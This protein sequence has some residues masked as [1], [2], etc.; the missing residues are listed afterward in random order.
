MPEAASLFSAL[1]E[2]DHREGLAGAR[3]ERL[4]SAGRPIPGV[5]VRVVDEQGRDAP[6]GEVGEVWVRGPNVMQGYWNLPEETA[7]VLDAG[8]WYHSRDMGRLDASG[9]LTLVDR[10]GDMIV[11]GGENVY[12]TEVEDAI[13]RHEGVLEACVVGVPDPEWVEA[14]C[15]VVVR[16]PGAELDEAGLVAHCKRELSRYKVPKR[17]VFVDE[18][19]KGGTGKVLKHVVRQQQAEAA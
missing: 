12:S 13:Y 14:V 9:Y 10:K 2:R 6:A 16:N 7:A 11:S 3:P 18:L 17:V 8:G 19:P 15:A 1:V 4:L 5:E